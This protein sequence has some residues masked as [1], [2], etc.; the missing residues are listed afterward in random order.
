MGVVILQKATR[1]KHKIYAILH[2]LTV[3]ENYND[4]GKVSLKINIY[5]D[6]FIVNFEL[7]W[8]C[9]YPKSGNS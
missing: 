3:V 8:Q 9:M 2:I 6:L 1:G 4:Y 7:Q 5:N